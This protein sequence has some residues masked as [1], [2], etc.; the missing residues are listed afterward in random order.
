M[1]RVP[2]QGLASAGLLGQGL[3]TVHSPASCLGANVCYLLGPALECYLRWI[4]V[5]LTRMTALLFPLGT[6]FSVLLTAAIGCAIR[7]EMAL[8]DFPVLGANPPQAHRLQAYR[9]APEGDKSQAPSRQT[10]AAI[11]SRSASFSVHG[12]SSSCRRRCL[13]GRG[14]RGGGCS[15]PDRGAA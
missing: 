10:V 8:Q 9:P 15:R 4:G 5:R 13:A 11:I 7:L 12:S 6:L 1:R 14:G 2:A 3:N